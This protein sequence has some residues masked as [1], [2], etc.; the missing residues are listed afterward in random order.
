MIT[1]LILNAFFVIRMANFLSFLKVKATF[2]NALLINHK[3]LGFENFKDILI[4]LVFNFGNYWTNL[5][6]FIIAKHLSR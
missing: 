3:K 6:Q 4:I 2:V 1:F 5:Q